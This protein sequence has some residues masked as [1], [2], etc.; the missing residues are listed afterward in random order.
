MTQIINSLTEISDR[1][2]A[3]LCDLWGCLHNGLAPFPAAEAALAAFRAKG[4]TVILLTNAPRPAEGVRKHLTHINVDAADYD[5]VI[6]SGDA[7]K[8]ALTA[9]MFGTD[10]YHIGPDRDLGFFEG[11]GVNRVALE[12][13]ESI[14]CTGLFDDESETPGDY[15]ATILYGKTK[16]MKLLCANPDIVVDRGDRRIYCA[17]ALAQAYSEAGGESMYFGKPHPPIYALARQMITELRGTIVDDARILCVGDGIK[18]DVPGGINEGM[19][20]LF[21]TGG[22][23]KETTGTDE[24]PDPALLN[25]HLAEA[26]LSPTAAMG[27]LR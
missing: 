13:A 15:A 3:I 24:Q 18:T 25:S 27:Y 16:G 22:L 20:T 10:V 23:S 1:Y 6:S 14:V 2:D 8:A 11:A 9:G 17:G 4:G 5:G 26:Q 7:A 12:E 19:D 21:I